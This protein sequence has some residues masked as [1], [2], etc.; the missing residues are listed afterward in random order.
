[1]ATLDLNEFFEEMTVFFRNQNIFTIAERGVTTNTDEFNG[2]TSTV[3]FQ[4]DRTNVKNVRSVTVDAAA[5]TFG[6]DYLVNYNDGNGKTT[7]TF[8]SAPGTGTDNVDIQY[9]YGDDTIYSDYPKENLRLDDFPRIGWDIISQSSKRGAVGSGTDLTETV[10]SVIVYEKTKR[11]MRSRIKSLK[12]SILSNQLN[13]F[14][15][16]EIDYLGLGPAFPSPFEK[17]KNKVI[18]QNVDFIIPHEFEE[19]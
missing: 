10:I 7:I 8:T 11:N 18:Q 16:T 13:F 12:D 15:I 17:G 9:D 19:A 4:I 2:D 6:T 14:Y 3:D 5:Q 1:M